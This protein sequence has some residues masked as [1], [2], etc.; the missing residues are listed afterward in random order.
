[1]KKLKDVKKIKER[2][3]SKKEIEDNEKISKRNKLYMYT[4]PLIIIILLVIIYI[5]TS[6]NYLLIPFAIF[7]LIFL[8]GMD[9]NQRTC[10]ECKKWNA[11]IWI[12]NKVILK[13][14]SKQKKNLIGKSVTKKIK[15]KVTTSTGK[16][17]NC[18]KEINVE[19]I[20][21]I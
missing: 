3:I 12:D 20:R 8:F 9:S 18:G 16:C 5:A 10:K 19:K 7:F 4:I 21:K 13:T 11:I 14:T 1:M 2:E 6:I 17:T 15:E